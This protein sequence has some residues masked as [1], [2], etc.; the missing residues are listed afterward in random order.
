MN[1]LE[2]K[3]TLPKRIEDNIMLCFFKLAV[4]SGLTVFN[5]IDG[6]VDEFEDETGVDTGASTNESYDAVND[7]YSPLISAEAA[8]TSYDDTGQQNDFVQI[9]GTGGVYEKIGMSFKIPTHSICTKIS[10]YL[11]KTNTPADNTVVRIET[12]N[13]GNPSGVLAHANATKSIASSTI[14]GVFGFVDFVF[15]SSFVLAANTTY[16]IVISRDGARDVTNYIGWGMDTVAPTYAGGNESELMSG[17]WVSQLNYDLLFRVYGT[18]VNNMTLVS[19]AVTAEAQPNQGRIALFEEDVDAVTINTDL[20]AYCSRDGGTTWT[21]LTLVD[22]GDYET[23]K[24]ILSS[25]AVAI[26][27]QPAGTSMKWKVET[28]NNKNLKLHAVGVNWG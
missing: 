14:G 13:A 2:Y 23:G 28:L 15:A 7:L 9:F 11:R 19:N 24:R 6:L 20:K 4:Q 18:I 8:Q 3:Y 1:R 16:H 17:A 10:A 21:Q 27:A 26:S 12:D 5:L 22:E 25:A